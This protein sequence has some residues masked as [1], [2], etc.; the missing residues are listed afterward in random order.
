LDYLVAPELG[1]SDDIRNVWPQPYTDAV[2]N[3][4]VKDA[5][6]D[7]LHELVCSGRISLATAQHDI[8]TNWVQA[9][10]KYFKTSVPLP[11]HYA[12]AKDMPWG[13]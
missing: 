4:H 8:A 10:K 9:Y 3:S 2:W 5:L 6:E 1:G 13:G 7:R 12:F 11:D